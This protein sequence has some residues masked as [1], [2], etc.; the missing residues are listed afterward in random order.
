MVGGITDHYFFNLDFPHSVT[1]FWLYAA[2]AVLTIKVAVGGGV[3][4]KAMPAAE[5]PDP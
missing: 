2:L 3:A 1:L 5:G 4:S